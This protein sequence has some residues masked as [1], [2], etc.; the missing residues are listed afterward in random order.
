MTTRKSFYVYKWYAD[1]ID[2]KTNDVAIIYLG[3]LEWNFLKISF[4]NI[5]QFLE[6]YHLISQT[7]FSNYNSPILKNKSFH[8]NSLQVSGQWESKSE[9][10]IEKLFENKDGYI[11]WECFMPSALGEIKIDEKKIFQGFG[12]VER[13]TLT[14]K[15]WQ[16]PINILRWGRFLCKN[17]YIVWIHWEGDEKKFLVFHNGMKYIDGI[18]N[19]DMIEFGYY[20]L[21][22]LKKYTLRNGPLIKTVFDKFLWIKKIF[23][24][25]FFNMKECKWQTWSELYE[26]N[27]SIANGWSIH[28]NVDCKPKMNC[29]GKI[30]YGSLFTILLPLIL[31]FWSK[32]TEKYILLPILTNSIVA[33]IFILLGLIL[34][35]SAMLDLWI[36]GDGLPMNAYPPSKLV[37]TGLYNIFS[38]PIYI[39]SSIFSF[40]LSIYF[41][42]KSGFWLMSPILTLSWLALVYGYENEDL[43]KRF[44]DIKWN[45]LLHLPEN[46]K[47]KS[48]FK[49]I[50]SAYCLV[51]IPWLIFYQMIIFIG[52]PLNSISTYLIFEINIPIIEWTEIFYLL[53]YPYVVLLPLILQT[54]QQIRSFILAGLINISIGI[55]LQIILPFVAVPR[56]FIPTTIL[57]QI[58]LHERDLDGPTG[59][60][61]SFHVSWAFLSGYYYSWN[62]PKLKFIFYILSILISL[63]CITTG[64][65]S[66]IDV[67]AGFLLFIICIKREILWIYIR[68]YFENLA[69]SWTYYRI[70]KLRI[71]NHSF[72][73]FLSSSTGVFIL[74]S[75]VGHT[76]TIIITSTLSVIGAGI[77]AQFIENTSGLSR[78]FGYF[79][80]ITGGTIGSIIASW[81]FNI[82]IILILSAYALASPLI[83]FIGRLRCVIQ[84]CCH[85][86]PTNKF[87][88]ILVKNPR[89]RVCSLS[90]LK[91]TYI[92]ITAGY[93]ML[94]N[95][96]IGLFLWRLWYS[97]VSLCLIVSLYFILIGLSR[98]VEEEYRG[99]I[100][101][102]IYYK[103]KIYQWTSILFVLIGMIISMIPFDDNASLKLIWKYEYVLPSILFGLATG[104]AMGVD[105]PESKR[106]FSR[107]SD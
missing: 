51:L 57:G 24:S 20:R 70:G 96:I 37:T 47:M 9:S 97:N 52:T 87:L 12:Y 94:A 67:I 49:D 21:M 26:N 65:H 81:L 13:L 63:S 75:L 8:I 101:T 84:G 99:E 17:Q 32:Q 73:A 79:G 35:F 100:Q 86:R 29:F 80:C 56:E 89:S 46:I 36:K 92:H 39:G 69:N 90:Y 27:C 44:P 14:L 71:I 5:L 107:L 7:T 19:D 93:S 62:F 40:G 77:W 48:Q 83:Q 74:C 104:F 42:S 98:F 34:M 30:F 18:I 53:A 106:K 59:A 25:G 28:E 50:I 76:Y 88:G 6:K 60:F 78:P 54:K 15:P 33:F 1:I 82:P 68:N 23:P 64:M 105:F 102:P 103:L 72:Y 91:D 85:G 10:I 38:H 11:L 16:I 55:Y 45:P 95:L 2:E 61:P 3:E 31:M 22:L 58:L 41:Q 66:I 43:R 4:T